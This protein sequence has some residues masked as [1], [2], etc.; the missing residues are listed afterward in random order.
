LN[1]PAALLVQEFM[2]SSRR[3]RRAVTSTTRTIPPSTPLQNWAPARLVSPRHIADFHCERCGQR[4]TTRLD[5]FLSG[6][7]RFERLVRLA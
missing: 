6:R 7:F 5:E 3:E 4:V 1:R 2:S